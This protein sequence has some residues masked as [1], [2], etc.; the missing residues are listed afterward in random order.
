MGERFSGQYMFLWLVPAV[1][2]G[3]ELLSPPDR[4]QTSIVQK[5]VLV[6]V[7]PKLELGRVRQPKTGRENIKR[8][9]KGPAWQMGDGIER[10]KSL[11]GIRWF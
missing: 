1:R 4:A 9:A 7:M 6:D 5:K 10:C 11:K 8:A 3:F 2:P